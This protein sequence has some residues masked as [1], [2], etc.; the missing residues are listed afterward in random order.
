MNHLSFLSDDNATSI[1]FAQTTFNEDELAMR[2]LYIEN[3]I[4]L[5]YADEALSAALEEYGIFHNEQCLR[6]AEFTSSEKTLNKLRSMLFEC[7]NYR[8]T[9]KLIDSLISARKAYNAK[10][11]ADLRAVLLSCLN[12]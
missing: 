4:R 3:S 6:L 10:E 8:M 7:S 9:A 5:Q 11:T 12:Q 2:L 1:Q